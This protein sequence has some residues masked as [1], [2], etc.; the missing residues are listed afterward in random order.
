M[1][2]DR[3]FEAWQ[4]GDLNLTS[5]QKSII[6]CRSCCSKDKECFPGTKMS[7]LCHTKDGQKENVVVLIPGTKSKVELILNKQSH[8]N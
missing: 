2:W 1:G 8:S 3:F 6:R 5:R 7:L 4:L